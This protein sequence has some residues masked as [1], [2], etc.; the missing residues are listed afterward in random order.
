MILELLRPHVR[1]LQGYST[2]RDEFSGTAEVYLDANENPF[3]SAINRYPDP[4]CRALKQRISELKGIELQRIFIGNGSDEA[5]DLLV[6]ALVAPGQ[7]IITTPPTYGMYAVTARAHG[8]SV[9]EVPMKV[10]FSLDYDGLAHADAQGGLLTFLCSPNNPTGIQLS[11]QEIEQVLLRARGVVVVDEAYIDFASGASACT[12]LKEYPHLVVLQTLSKAWGMAGARVGL[13]FGDPRLI[14]ALSKLKLPYNVNALS[15]R[16]A[17]G[18]LAD[19]DLYGQQVQRIVRERER[20]A[21]E[22]SKMRTIKAVFPSEGNF[23]LVRCVD[24]RRL[25]EALRMQGII[26]R[27]RSYE[28]HCSECLRI[29]VGTEVENDRLLE[30]VRGFV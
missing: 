8:V 2:A 21:G 14:A 29:T 3:E 19:T 11:L 1:A 25:F 10:D 20:L 23:L 6:R 4:H 24:A 13:A 9:L 15:Q 27:D 12:L 18:R 26:V 7:S 22:L 30:A 16:V 5:I 28:V 17:L